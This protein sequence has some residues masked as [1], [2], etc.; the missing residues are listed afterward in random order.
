M[1]LQMKGLKTAV[2]KRICVGQELF[3]LLGK[4]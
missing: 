1:K 2:S 3:M 4:W